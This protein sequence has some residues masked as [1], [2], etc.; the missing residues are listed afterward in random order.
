MKFFQVYNILPPT[1]HPPKKSTD[2]CCQTNRY[3]Q[4][5]PHKFP[6]GNMERDT[7]EPCGLSSATNTA[8]RQPSQAGTA[9]PWDA[10]GG[11]HQSCR[12]MP[13][14]WRACPSWWLHMG[15][16]S[17]GGLHSRTRWVTE[18]RR[19]SC[20]ASNAD[21]VSFAAILS[22]WDVK[23][24]LLAHVSSAVLRSDDALWTAGCT[25]APHLAATDTRWRCT[26]SFGF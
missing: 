20:K 15:T 10:G 1:C 3:V 4:K 13:E 7:E 22:W 25:A 11:H 18:S 14:L 23:Y 6:T 8:K 16:E 24:S 9:L 26:Y 17:S 21:W 12:E 2:S 5:K 19:N